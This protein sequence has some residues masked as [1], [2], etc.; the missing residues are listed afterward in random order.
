MRG[1]TPLDGRTN[2]G[3]RFGTASRTIV[4][5]V[6]SSLILL[7]RARAG[8]VTPAAIGTRSSTTLRG[9]SVA[10]VV[11]LYAAAAAAWILLSDRVVTILIPP[12]EPQA[13]AQSLKGLVFVTTTALL[14]VALLANEARAI[15]SAQVALIARDHEL[16]AARARLDAV[17]AN[18]P[19]AVEVV[20]REGVIELWNPAAEAIFG[21]PAAEVTNRRN[22]TV[23]PGGTP[24]YEAALAA[25]FDG[26][27]PGPTE[28]ERQ[29][30]DGSPVTVR[31]WLAPLRDES[32]VSTA[33]ITVLQD[34][35]AERAL[36]ARLE[37]HA[38]LATAL[39]RLTAGENPQATG[40]AICA[41]IAALPD[42][43][44]AAVLAFGAG[45]VV[46]PL[47]VAGPPQRALVPGRPIPRARGSHL[48]RHAKLY[49]WAEAWH[50]GPAENGY[51][52]KLAD[53]GLRAVAY[54]PLR[55]D[56][57]PVGLLVIGSSRVDGVDWLSDRLPEI[58]QV[59]TVASA[60]LAPTLRSR[61]AADDL[62]AR[63]RRVIDDRAFQPVFQP[64]VALAT[65]DPVG[66]E[67]L[68]RFEDGLAPDLRFSEAEAVGLGSELEL[69]CLAA[70]IEAARAL[71]P[72]L[73]LNVN[74]SPTLVLDDA[75]L[76]PVL[77]SAQQRVQIEITEHTAIRDY[78]ALRDA[79]KRQGETVRLAVDDAGAGHASLRH[80]L[81]L[82]P[83]TVKL[84]MGL[85]RGVDTD[86]S[87]Q[88][89]I[90]GM[91]HFARQTDCTLVAE[92]VETEA[93]RRTLISL[94]IKYGQGYL[95]GRPRASAL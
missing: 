29:R 13:V 68:T 34:L 72:E 46:T 1:A 16:T 47:A 20:G 30:R 2:G 33:A 92:G 93:E 27:P 61:L 26:S 6:T 41:A 51:G 56:G 5:I 19:L 74:I 76:R 9:L 88:A 78:G 4:D 86:A 58:G 31:R 32:G 36:E 42:F 49:P 64:I 90:A 71:D 39:A 40:A 8:R 10:R 65:G 66:Y 35:T 63:I 55:E 67:A 22:P 94:G 38:M 17:L 70:A 52:A 69:A 60:L 24:R 37:S 25:T 54:A 82:R 50:P 15:R 59:A 91:T 3:V 57:P 83:T 44:S 11:G 73:M 62:V 14:L 18:A 77:A 87:R 7:L 89:L 80:I 48:R 45:D 79:I 85:I 28:V 75:A 95:F 43:E 53:A 12:G 84:D 81:E 23:P 21:W